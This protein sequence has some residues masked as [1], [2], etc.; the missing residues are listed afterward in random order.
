MTTVDFSISILSLWLSSRGF[1]QPCSLFCSFSFIHTHTHEHLHIYISRRATRKTHKQNT[2]FV[3]FLNL[4][5]SCSHLVKFHIIGIMLNLGLW[6]ILPVIKTCACCIVDYYEN[7]FCFW[8]LW[9]C[10][11]L[12]HFTPEYKTFQNTEDVKYKSVCHCSLSFRCLA[13]TLSLHTLNHIPHVSPDLKTQSFTARCQL[14]HLY[15]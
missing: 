5:F 1:N 9:Y 6:L 15:C 7:E 13:Y 10:W 12:H 8:C 14:L 2:Q 11:S 4:N 3:P